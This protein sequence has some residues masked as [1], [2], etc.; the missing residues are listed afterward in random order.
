MIAVGDPAKPDGAVVCRACAAL[1]ADEQ[2]R[3]HDAVMVRPLGDAT[4]DRLR[5]SGAQVSR[6]LGKPSP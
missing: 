1:P 5:A 4:A 6:G 2:R 3:R